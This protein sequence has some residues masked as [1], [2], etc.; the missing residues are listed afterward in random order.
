M[1]G[2]AVSFLESA[3]ALL[4]SGLKVTIVRDFWRSCVCV[5][6]ADCVEYEKLL[7]LQLMAVLQV[8]LELRTKSPRR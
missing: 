2:F 8:S 6:F 5:V 3:T 4:N 7:C 1:L